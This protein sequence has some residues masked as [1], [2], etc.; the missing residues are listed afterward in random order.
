MHPL[1]FHF[2]HTT[3]I[4]DCFVVRKPCCK[5]KVREAKAF[6]ITFS[7]GKQRSAKRSDPKE[8]IQAIFDCMSQKRSRIS[9]Q[10]I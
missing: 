9:I 8:I 10:Y 1:F 3:M 7:L 2:N 5:L 4:G 6:L